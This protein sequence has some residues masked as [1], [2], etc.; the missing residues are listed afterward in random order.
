MEPIEDNEPVNNGDQNKGDE[1]QYTC[2][3]KCS[4]YLHWAELT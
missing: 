1:K 2:L 3:D 4:W